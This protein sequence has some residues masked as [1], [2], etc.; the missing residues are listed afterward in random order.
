MYLQSVLIEAK[1]L[2]NG[3]SIV[4]PKQFDTIEYF[5]IELNSHD[6]ILAEGAWSETFVDDESRGMFHNAHEY[7]SRY[8][9]E[10][11]QPA[12]YCAPRVDEGYE[13]EAVRRTIAERAGVISERSAQIGLL[14][15]YLDVVSAHFIAGWAQNVDHPEVPVCLDIFAGGRLIGQTLANL[16]RADLL[17]AGI[18]SGSH[19]FEF[20]PPPGLVLTDLAVRR[21]IDGALLP[22]AGTRTLVSRMTEAV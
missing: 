12:R 17:R 15:G 13:L 20:K 16:L 11:T 6:V 8:P 5:H 3:V 1:D 2:V 18:G 22:S 10:V 4:Q 21:S 19:S 9:R 14:R 7:A